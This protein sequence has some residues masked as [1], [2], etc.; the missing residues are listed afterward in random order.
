M[1]NENDK[2]LSINFKFNDFNYNLNFNK[3]IIK[4]IDYEY[5]KNHTTLYTIDYMKKYF[6]KLYQINI[7]SEVLLYTFFF[8]ITLYNTMDKYIIIN[9]LNN[10]IQIIFDNKDNDYV[11]KN[12]DELFLNI[13]FKLI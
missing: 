11:I 1:I 5:I 7:I 4:I 10:M 13:L 3:Y 8:F 2:P 9:N 12:F 6:N